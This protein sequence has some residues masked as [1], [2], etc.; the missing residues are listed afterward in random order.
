MFLVTGTVFCQHLSDL[1]VE[2]TYYTVLMV[3]D[4]RSHQSVPLL[5]QACQVVIQALLQPRAPRAA[6][7]PTC[8]LSAV[9]VLFLFLLP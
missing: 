3:I 1:P 6:Q 4:A 5:Y 9:L 2:F 7:F 8:D